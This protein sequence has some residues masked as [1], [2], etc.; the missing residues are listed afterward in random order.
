MKCE[1]RKSWYCAD[2]ER[3]TTTSNAAVGPRRCPRS[4]HPHGR[5]S[6]RGGLFPR[7]ACRIYRRMI[8]SSSGASIYRL[9]ICGGPFWKRKNVSIR[10]LTYIYTT[11]PK[12]S[13]DLPTLSIS[14]RGAAQPISFLIS[15]SRGNIRSERGISYIV[16]ILWRDCKQQ[17]LSILSFNEVSKGLPAIV[18]SYSEGF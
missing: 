14:F 16:Y 6:W 4:R 12:D 15:G 11:G 13:V 7:R 5:S 9:Y 3:E 8:G 2:G 18:F 1:R 10:L 17:E